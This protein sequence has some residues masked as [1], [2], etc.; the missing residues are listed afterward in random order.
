MTLQHLV[1]D[2]YVSYGAC[3]ARG[4]WG[5]GI[6]SLYVCLDDLIGCC[7]EMIVQSVGLPSHPPPASCSQV[8]LS[9]WQG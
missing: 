7:L 8:L 4:E 1:P 6:Q 2:L 5:P 3:E 9:T